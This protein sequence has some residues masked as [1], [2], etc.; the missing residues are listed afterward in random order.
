MNCEEDQQFAHENAPTAHPRPSIAFQ[1]E[2][3]LLDTYEGFRHYLMNTGGTSL[4]RERL[5]IVQTLDALLLEESVRE[6]AST[7]G[8]TTSNE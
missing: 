4:E 1:L 6:P 8:R 5:R 3:H 7:G 2:D